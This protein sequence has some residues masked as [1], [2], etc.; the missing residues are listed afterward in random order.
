MSFTARVARIV[1]LS[2]ATALESSPRVTW[3]RGTESC[4]RPS[5]AGCFDGDTLIVRWT[6]DGVNVP[7]ECDA[8]ARNAAFLKPL[9]TGSNDE[10]FGVFQEDCRA[11]AS[12]IPPAGSYEVD[13]C[14][15][16]ARKRRLADGPHRP[17]HAR[18]Q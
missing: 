4:H 9:V 3:R 7:S 18:R 14:S 12:N 15:S 6:V 16:T 11:F 2:F 1:L 13:A 17:L 5:R 10:V 8:P